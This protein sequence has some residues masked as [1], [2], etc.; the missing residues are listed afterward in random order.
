MNGVLTAILKDLEIM[1]A[2]I[3]GA[4]MQFMFGSNKSIRTGVIIVLS[5]VFVAMYVVFPLMVFL[6]M[7]GEQFTAGVYAL[8]SLISVEILAILIT[9]LPKAMSSKV[10]NFIGVKDDTTNKNR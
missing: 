6:D 8:S 2:V 3:F 7:E 1:T 4:F 10:K 9:F 5:S